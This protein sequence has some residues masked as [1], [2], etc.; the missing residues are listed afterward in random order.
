MATITGFIVVACIIG[1]QTLSALTGGSLSLNVG[2]VV[3]GIMTLL[4]C[5]CGFKFIHYFERWSW[6]PSLIA[7]IVA[8][9]CGGKYLSQ[10][11]ETEAPAASTIISFGALIA[12]F[13]IPWSG[14][15]SDL[16]TYFRPDVS[17]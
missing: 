11:V 9:G 8:T 4:I 10:Q 6:I 12:G 16:S 7:C 14:L 17:P 13:F 2:I 15:A 3:I 5:F 1:G